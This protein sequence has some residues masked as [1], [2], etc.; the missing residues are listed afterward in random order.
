[1]GLQQKISQEDLVLYEVIK[2][3]VLFGEFVYNLDIDPKLDTTFEFTWY[4]RE[5]LGDFNPRVSIAT[6]RATGKTV[7][8]YSILLWI[9]SYN[10]FP[11]D[12]ILFT[13]PSKVH[14]EPVFTNL[15][16]LLK[17]NSFLKNFIDI[18]SGVNSSEFKIT[19]KNGA[20]LLCRIAG[21]SG[22]GSNLIALHTP[23][24]IVDEGGY[25]PYNAF[26][27]MQPSLNVWTPGH[28]EIVSGVPTGMRE[29][30]VLYTV[31]QENDSYTKHRVSAYD[32][33]R[34]TVEDI[35]AAKEQ[36]GGVESEDFIHY[37]LGQHGKPVYSLFD[38]GLFKIETYP[39]FKLNIDG[40]KMD[41]VGEVLSKIESFPNIL[42]KHYG[43]VIG[44]DLGYTEPTA[45]CIL[46]LDGHERFRFHGR[47]KLTKVS[48]PIQEKII[49]LLDTKYS[50]IIFGIDRGSSGLSV[51]Q[52]LQEHQ[53]YKHKKFKERI[54][55]IEFSSSVVIGTNTDGEENKI[56]AKPFFVSVLQEMANSHRVIFSTTDMDMV[57]ELER[58]TYSKSPNGDISYKTITERGGKRGEDHFTSALMS[59][60]GAFHMVREFTNSSPK[61]K[62]MRALWNV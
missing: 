9:L 31:D 40:L 3:P 60:V 13:V 48:Y 46:Y 7:S 20:V 24:I 43:I 10:V 2:N 11:E 22:T 50:P 26:N 51:L 42:E 34:I 57:T 59:G 32:N 35:E 39:V 14:L 62:L 36:Y 47:I 29:N 45:I 19:L 4:Q 28:R 41:D 56:K 15:V 61:I 58:M 27:E 55:P 5:I 1:M 17:T 33:P 8:D 16:R 18:R 6:A 12:Y 49:D 44:V 21:Q 23:F 38:R 25:F 37:V 53:E 30:N 54:Y 52:T